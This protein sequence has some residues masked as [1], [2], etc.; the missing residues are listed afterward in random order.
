ML[1]KTA[2]FEA[3]VNSALTPSLSLTTKEETARKSADDAYGIIPR[4]SLKHWIIGGAGMVANL[5]KNPGNLPRKWRTFMPIRTKSAGMF[6]TK[7]RQIFD[8][9]TAPV[10]GVDG[11]ISAESGLTAISPRKKD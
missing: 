1:W 2:F 5:V 8:R 7:K 9:Y 3:Q 6:G 4:T 11:D 10:R